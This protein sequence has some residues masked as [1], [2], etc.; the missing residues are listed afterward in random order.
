MP[1][2]ASRWGGQPAPGGFMRAQRAP[3]PN[4]GES[5]EGSVRIVGRECCSRPRVMFSERTAERMKVT[6]RYEV[7]GLATGCLFQTQL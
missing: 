1:V 5:R 7:L 6:C 2:A 4:D 3:A